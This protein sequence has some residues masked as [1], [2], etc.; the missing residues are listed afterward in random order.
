MI[1]DPDIIVLVGCLLYIVV[2]SYLIL[3]GIVT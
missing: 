2:L 3:A 1:K